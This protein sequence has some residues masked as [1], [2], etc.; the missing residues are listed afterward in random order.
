MIH[1]SL[2]VVNWYIVYMTNIDQHGFNWYQWLCCYIETTRSNRLYSDH[3]WN[4]LPAKYW[5]HK[6][7]WG[8]NK[9]ASS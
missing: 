6:F 9:P 2:D 5:F 4:G 3:V 1:L 7:I 8:I